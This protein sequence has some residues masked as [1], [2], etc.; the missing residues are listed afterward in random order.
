MLG[1]SAA[2]IKIRIPFP[3]GFIAATFLLESSEGS[4]VNR[5]SLTGGVQTFL[6]PGGVYWCSSGSGV[7]HEQIPSVPGPMLQGLQ[8]FIDLPAEHKLSNPSFQLIAPGDVPSST[9]DSGVV[10]RTLVGG[11]SPI[12]T[13]VNISVSEISIPPGVT[14]H[15]T[16]QM[17]HSTVVIHMLSGTVTVED[18]VVGPN[19]TASVI[20]NQ[21]GSIE[22][23][24]SQGSGSLNASFFLFTGVPLS[25][26]AVWGGPF[27]M[28]DEAQLLDRQRAFQMGEMGSLLPSAVKWAPR[29]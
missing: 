24:N 27:L 16:L 8:V 11:E 4:I 28:L 29:N 18:S 17:D 15:H 1:F 14:L 3:T 21:P 5:D 7:L 23:T 12:E 6:E 19:D 25:Q 13:L 26:P 10:I 20:V 22:I 9:S 2:D